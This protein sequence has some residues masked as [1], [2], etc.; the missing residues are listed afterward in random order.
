M[1]LF[2][3]I[4]AKLGF[5]KPEPAPAPAPSPLPVPPVAKDLDPEFPREKL[6]RLA[7]KKA[8]YDLALAHQAPSLPRSQWSRP[9]SRPEP[10][11]SPYGLPQPL[12]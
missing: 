7:A 1:G 8:K 3:S 11:R 12:L 2:G 9:R 5:G 4:L 10:I 6:H